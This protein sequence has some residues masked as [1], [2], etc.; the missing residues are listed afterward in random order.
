MPAEW[1]ARVERAQI[2]VEEA[3]ARAR[4]A[5]TAAERLAAA[6][7][8]ADAVAQFKFVSGS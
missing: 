1:R 3:L 8:A 6:Q 7:V 2:V 4:L 5:V